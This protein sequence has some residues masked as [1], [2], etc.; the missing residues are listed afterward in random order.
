MLTHLLLATC[1]QVAA[2]PKDVAL[3]KVRTTCVYRSV[4]FPSESQT[5][6]FRETYEVKPDGSMAVSKILVENLMDGDKLPIPDGLEPEQWSVSN[7]FTKPERTPGLDDSSAFRLWRL[8][9]VP[10]PGQK[11]TWSATQEWPAASASCRESG[12]SSD[13][14]KGVAVAFDFGEANGMRGRGTGMW[15]KTGGLRSGK[16]TVENAFLPGGDYAPHRLEISWQP[17]E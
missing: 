14:K 7:P 4:E 12:F 16:L 9:Q 1:L 2:I 3:W 8:V 17:L 13:P 6:V 15:G 5:W 10:P 11:L